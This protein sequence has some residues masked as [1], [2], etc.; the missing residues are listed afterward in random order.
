MTKQFKIN[1]GRI[2][3]II[4]QLLLSHP[5]FDYQYFTLKHKNNYISILKFHKF[6]INPKYLL[7][8]FIIYFKNLHFF[9]KE[10]KKYIIYTNNNLI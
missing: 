1:E 3:V 8:E 2:I 5:I 9:S 4:H 7:A 6:E 10:V